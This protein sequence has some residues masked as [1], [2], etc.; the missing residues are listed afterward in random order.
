MHPFQRKK[1]E[2]R[3]RAILKRMRK[4]TPKAAD[5]ERLAAIQRL[6]G[7]DQQREIE[8]AAPEYALTK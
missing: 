2:K 4:G 7:R 5:A 8:R 1:L 6:L 3:E